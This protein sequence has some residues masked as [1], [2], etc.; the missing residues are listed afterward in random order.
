MIYRYTIDDGG[1]DGRRQGPMI[2]IGAAE[3]R[4][5]YLADIISGGGEIE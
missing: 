2:H 5:R 4:N 1:Y 3:S